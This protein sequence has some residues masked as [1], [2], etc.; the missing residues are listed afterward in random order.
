MPLSGYSCNSDSVTP[1]PDTPIALVQQQS[2]PSTSVIRSMIG[3]AR[4][5]VTSASTRSG[6]VTPATQDLSETEMEVTQNNQNQIIQ[7]TNCGNIF[8]SYIF[9]NYLI[10]QVLTLKS[11]INFRLY[12]SYILQQLNN[13]NSHYIIHLI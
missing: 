5:I 10:K 12:F 11:N 2:Q 9:I 4:S 8:K 1:V 13:C 3:S 6:Q 7:L